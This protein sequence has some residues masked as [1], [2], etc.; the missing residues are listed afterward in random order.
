MASKARRFGHRKVGRERHVAACIVGRDDRR[1][2]VG[3]SG[4]E[5]RNCRGQSL[6]DRRI[7]KLARELG[8]LQAI[9]ARVRW[10]FG[11]QP[12][13]AREW[14]AGGHCQVP[15]CRETIDL[16]HSGVGLRS[17]LRSA[18]EQHRR[19]P[20]GAWPLH[21]FGRD[22]GAKRFELFELLGQQ[23]RGRPAVA[24]ASRP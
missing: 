13:I 21:S 16:G 8:Q 5:L 2:V 20:L 22:R 19:C 10:S 1:G 3:Q 4:A 15:L 6:D 12:G 14:A 7:G 17:Q 24:L 9:A 11:R 18:H 23:L